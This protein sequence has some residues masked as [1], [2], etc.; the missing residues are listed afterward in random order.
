MVEDCLDFKLST[1]SVFY[2]ELLVFSHES[3]KML[4][5]YA[6]KISSHWVCLWLLELNNNCCFWYWVWTAYTQTFMMKVT[7]LI[8]QSIHWVSCL[9]NWGTT[10]PP[11]PH[12]I[13]LFWVSASSTTGSWSSYIAPDSWTKLILPLRTWEQLIAALIQRK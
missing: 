7:Q 5:N 3:V 9:P 13:C 1:K 2:V 8:L 12:L 6:T 4:C 10:K 11:C